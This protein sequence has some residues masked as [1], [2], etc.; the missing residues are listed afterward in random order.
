MDMKAR[1]IGLPPV[2]PVQ[3]LLYR[4]VTTKKI[5]LVTA[6]CRGTLCV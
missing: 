5:G 3:P 4:I 6:A 1:K 2:L